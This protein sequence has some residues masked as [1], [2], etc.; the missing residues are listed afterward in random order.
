[1]R[2]VDS[3]AAWGKNPRLRRCLFFYEAAPGN[4]LGNNGNE[5]TKTVFLIVVDKEIQKSYIGHIPHGGIRCTHK[6]GGYSGGM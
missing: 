1:M 4:I 6:K 5:S 2:K 3:A